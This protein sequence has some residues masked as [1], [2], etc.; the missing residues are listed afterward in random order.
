MVMMFVGG[1]AFIAH[2]SDAA[3]AVLAAAQVAVAGL[4]LG[5]TV[6]VLAIIG[7]RP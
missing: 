1:A 6:F 7:W 3:I 2:L 4:A 5:A